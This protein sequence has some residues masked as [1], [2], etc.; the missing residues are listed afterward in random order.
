MPIDYIPYIR[1]KVGHD[2]VLAI[3]LACLIINEKREILLEKRADNS[4]YCV[5]GGALDLYETITDG[6]K[7]EVKEETGIELDEIH[8]FGI[9]SGEQ[10]KIQYPNGDVTHY[11]DIV[12]YSHVSSIG[13][14]F[15]TSDIESKEIFFCSLDHLPNKELFLR[16]SYEYIE[17]YINNNFEITIE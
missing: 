12:F 6:V 3:G 16:G 15:K 14:Q 17:K 9:K 1:K 2:E 10:M 4:L 11:V 13:L 5:P 7:R 8:L